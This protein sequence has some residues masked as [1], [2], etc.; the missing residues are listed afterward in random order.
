MSTQN[1]TPPKRGNF[2]V[3][4]LKSLVEGRNAKLIQELIRDESL[5]IQL[6]D[7]YINVYYRGGNILRI[8]PQSY[9]FDK[10][11]FYLRDARSFPKTY[12]EK[13]ATGKSAEIS[14]LTKNAV[15][16]KDEAIRIV[17]QL[18]NERQQLIDFLPE[19][20]D[21]YLETAKRTMDRWFD[22]WEKKERNDQHTI[23]LSNRD[24]S[25]ESDLVVVDLEFAVSPLQSYNHATNQN[26]DKKICRFDI[27]AVAR[28]GQIYVIELKQNTKADLDGNG[29][30]VND[31]ARDFKD[32]IGRDVS[33]MFAN[34]IF[35]L[36][37]MKQ[38]LG[39]FSDK[40]FVDATKPPV[41]AVAFSG[42]DS[43]DF[44][45]KYEAKGLQI[46]K[47]VSKD[48]HKYLKVQ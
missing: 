4:F 35:E 30:N 2:S 3:R 42:E 45:S 15:P 33:N 5:D 18:T 25:D 47:V 29:S 21:E 10:Y 43:E 6:R 44:N 28:D 9:D 22:S 32:T 23:S 41:F 7:N 14:P 27:I 16:T 12:I 37:N 19:K 20:V 36:V 39:I 11:Y 38:R 26:G 17:T 48:N 31:H 24:F 34:E 1:L 8:H 13:V 46:I 40:I